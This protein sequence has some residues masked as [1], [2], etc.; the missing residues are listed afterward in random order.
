MSRETNVLHPRLRAALPK[1]LAAMSAA[2]FPMTVTETERMEE[3]QLALYAKGRTASGCIVTYCDGVIKKS[4]HQKSE[5]TFVHAVDCTSLVNNVPSWDLRNP[6]KVYGAL[7]EAYGLTWGGNW[8]SL[9]DLPHIEV[10]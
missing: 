2:G 5:D 1:I 8:Q 7:A 10:T 9:H 4:H 3:E 6:W